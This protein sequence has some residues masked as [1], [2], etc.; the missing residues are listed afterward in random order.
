MKDLECEDDSVFGVVEDRYT[1]A[2]DGERAEFAMLDAVPYGL[3][4]LEVKNDE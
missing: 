1:L 4:G 2:E 3:L